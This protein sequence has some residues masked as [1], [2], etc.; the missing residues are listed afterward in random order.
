MVKLGTKQTN[1][2]H[3]VQLN[4]LQ[5][6]TYS[7]DLAQPWLTLHEKYLVYNCLFKIVCFN[8]KRRLYMKTFMKFNYLKQFT[9]TE[10]KYKNNI[11]QAML[12]NHQSNVLYKDTLVEL[13]LANFGVNQMVNCALVYYHKS[14]PDTHYLRKR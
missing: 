9:L 1:P 14:L 4:V 10:K 3:Q 8:K 11:L 13:R 7:V 5:R 12:A 6:I 2:K